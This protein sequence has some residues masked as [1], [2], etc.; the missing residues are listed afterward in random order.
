MKSLHGVK[1]ISFTENHHNFKLTELE[2]WNFYATL[3]S[4]VIYLCLSLAWQPNAFYDFMPAGNPNFGTFA[5]H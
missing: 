3:C 1:Y 4:L 2:K 5:K